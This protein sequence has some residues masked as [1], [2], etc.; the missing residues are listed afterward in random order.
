MITSAYTTAPGIAAA[1][2]ADHARKCNRFTRAVNL[3]TEAD[4]RRAERVVAY[5]ID[6]NGGQLTDDLEN[7]LCRMF[8][9][10]GG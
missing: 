1:A 8:K 7:I 9:D 10:H 4:P 5:L 2:T 6:L 3:P